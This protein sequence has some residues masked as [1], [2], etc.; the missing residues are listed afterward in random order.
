MLV[1]PLCYEI[2]TPALVGFSNTHLVL[3]KHSGRAALHHRLK[4]LGFQVSRDELQHICYRFVALAD[5]KKSWT[6]RVRLP[7]PRSS[8]SRDG[9]LLAVVSPAIGDLV[10][11]GIE[12]IDAVDG[13]TKWR[14]ESAQGYRCAAF[15]PGGASIA[16]GGIDGFARVLSVA[17][18]SEL[19]RIPHKDATIQAV[20]FS[21]DRRFLN[22]CTE[23]GC[24][25]HSLIAQ[26]LVD[27]ACSRVS[28][29]LTQKEWNSHV[30]PPYRQIC[31]NL[32]PGK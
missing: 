13:S 6:H 3:G 8:F 14:R 31:P 32:P 1:N 27:E 25:A 15:D 16:V 22:T 18:G 12:L 9:R 10:P 4:E 30:A 2:M 23:R 28:R 29:N 5:R 7:V 21:S 20:A 19:L 24:E 11:G 17:D 26:D